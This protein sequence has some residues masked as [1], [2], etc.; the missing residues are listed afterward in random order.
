LQQGVI[1]AFA[2]LRHITAGGGNSERKG[3]NAS[4]GLKVPFFEK[5]LRDALFASRG[6]RFDVAQNLLYACDT[7]A[8][9]LWQGVITAA[10]GTRPAG[11]YGSGTLLGGTHLAP[12]MAGNLAARKRASKS[13][14]LPGV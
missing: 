7:Y 2:P 1:H 10:M 14:T 5:G 4:L 8:R 6:S 12:R 3:T 11:V 13:Y 9:L